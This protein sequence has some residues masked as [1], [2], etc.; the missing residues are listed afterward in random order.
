MQNKLSVFLSAVLIGCFASAAQADP[1]IAMY[2]GDFQLPNL[3]GALEGGSG[4][5]PGWVTSGYNDVYNTDAWPFTGPGTPAQVL[6][7][8]AGQSAYQVLNRTYVE[9]AVYT[10]TVN[11]IG[12]FGGDVTFTM[13]LRDAA[14]HADLSALSTAT[15]TISGIAALTMYLTPTSLTYTATAADVGKQIEVYLSAS[16]AILYDNVTLNGISAVLPPPAATPIVIYNGDFQVPDLGAGVEGGAPPGWVTI[17]YNDV[18]NTNAWPFTGPGTP[19][20]GLFQAATASAYQE[21]TGANSVYVEGGVYTFTVNQIGGFGGDVTFTMALRDAATHADLSALATA[22]PTISG[23][24]ALTMYLTPTSLTYTATAADAGKQIEVY[25]N[26]V[27]NI[28]YDNVTLSAVLPASTTIVNGDFQLPVLP[29]AGAPSIYEG[30]VP[31]GWV[32]SGYNDVYNTDGLALTGPGTPAQVL[33]QAAVASAYQPINGT[34]VEGAVYTFTVNQIGNYVGGDLTFTMALRDAGTHLDLSALS[35]A[36]PTISGIPAGTMYLTPTSLAYT[37]TAADAGKQIEVYLAA[38]CPMIYDNVTL[39]IVPPS[40]NAFDT[41]ATTT[42][43]LSGAAA[44]FDA[45]P[46]HDGIPNGIEFVIGGQPNPANPGSNSSSLLPT[47]ASVGNN[48]VFTYTLMN[49]AAYL[50]PVVEFDTDLQGMWTTAV[51]GVNATIVVTPG[52]PA[53]TVV[54]TIPKGANPELFARLKVTQ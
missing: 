37:A 2:N 51:D 29:L 33:F 53:A 44:A 5:V 36:T 4:N 46:D 8:A 18:Y 42:N 41:W 31:P 15:P 28:L 27:S 52:D 34:Y 20:Q 54:V 6:F 40:A 9:G 26:A 21:L 25:L 10:F 3:G 7:Q 22:T 23:I 39:G 11:Q 38:G 50:N 45:D 43:G 17:G 12:G 13:A 48:L 35:T 14:T 32:T 24:A 47:A 16:N 49:A 19:A 30:L 1:S